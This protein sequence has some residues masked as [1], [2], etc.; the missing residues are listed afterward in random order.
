MKI[1]TKYENQVQ[2]NFLT[3]FPWDV[4]GDLSQ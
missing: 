1:E 3:N 4:Y 2:L